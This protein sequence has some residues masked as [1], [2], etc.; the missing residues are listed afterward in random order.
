MVGID[1]DA[2]KIAHVFNSCQGKVPGNLIC[3]K[4]KVLSLGLEGMDAYNQLEPTTGRSLRESLS[5]GLRADLAA[6]HSE[7]LA[8]LTDAGRLSDTELA[9][10]RRAPSAEPAARATAVA[11]AAELF[12][13][14]RR[15]GGRH[16]V[17]SVVGPAVCRRDQPRRQD[18]HA[19]A[20]SPLPG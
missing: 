10:W 14:A 7:L 2:G 11:K 19:A 5:E 16:L 12:G 13:R 1:L 6:T 9:V 17:L 15:T 20:R 4:G 8:R 18:R 3:H